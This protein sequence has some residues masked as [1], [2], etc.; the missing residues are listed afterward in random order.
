MKS[1]KLSTLKTPQGGGALNSQKIA[2]NGLNN[3]FSSDLKAEEK[4]L[5]K[6]Q[7]RGK[8]IA[9]ILSIIFLFTALV[10][11]SVFLIVN[12]INKITALESYSSIGTLTPSRSSQVNETVY[13][14]L[15]SKL[16]SKTGTVGTLDGGTPIVITMA[17]EDWQVVYR[18]PNNTDII[19]VWMCDYYTEDVF[20]SSSVDYSSSDIRTTVKNYFSTCA[21]N[22]PLLNSITVSPSNMSSAYKTAQDKQ[23]TDDYTSDLGAL[24][25][26]SDKFWLPSYYETFS[27]WGLDATD[28][29][30][31]S[32]YCWLRSGLSS[33]SS[34]AMLV[35]SSGSASYDNVGDGRGVRPAC[36]I[37][38]SALKATLTTTVTLNKQSGSGG[39]SSVSC[40]GG[41]AMPSITIPTR[42]GYTFGGY[43][44]STNGGGTQYYTA[45][46]ASA[47]SYPSSG[48][49]TVLYAKW[50][51]NTYYVKYNAN[52]GSGTMSNSTHKYGTAS[53]LTA[54]EFTYTGH[55]FAGW[56]T[57]STGAVVYA[58]GASVSTLTSTSGGTVDL[59]A[60]WSINSYTITVNINITE[61]GTVVGAGTHNYGTTATIYAVPEIGYTL[62]YWQH[63]D[64]NG[65]EIERIYTNPCT[66]MVT[67]DDT[68]TAVFSDSLITD[69]VVTSTI[70]GSVELV[71]DDFA[72]LADS[73]TIT[74]VARLKLNGY[75][76]DGWFV[77][78]GST[79]ISTAWSVKM[80]YGEL[81]GKVVIAKFSKISA[82]VNTE[83]NN[84]ANLT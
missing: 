13:N 18:D 54:N 82:N 53:N 61:A 1:K 20:D 11:G 64:V 67:G 15:I 75:Q 42:T 6:E 16:G 12:H 71:G 35:R 80:A 9:L 81:K 84:T 78:G 25:T 47:R 55:N 57:S 46:G 32:G 60:V 17:G 43:Y 69:I 73:D 37:S 5:K 29:A 33:N 76:F 14:S 62:L 63:L 26:Y 23:Y 51:G 28:R 79:A 56:A 34:C 50:T 49:P 41:S 83:T 58:D 8:I 2:E 70:G 72:N 22:Y 39:T 7:K 52:G 3:G 24:S 44:T 77:E 21:G 65:N 68:Y 30:M 4:P 48:G 45:T 66:T 19:T 10:G 27:F 40:S 36:H 38:L 31:A 74:L 59:Y